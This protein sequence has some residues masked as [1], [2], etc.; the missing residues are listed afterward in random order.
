MYMYFYVNSIIFYFVFQYIFKPKHLDVKNSYYN[1][2][3]I[4]YCPPE[5]VPNHVDFVTNFDN[6]EVEDSIGTS[7]RN[8]VIN[9]QND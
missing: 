5:E 4:K 1:N 8:Y 9:F 2:P 3:F 6:D 7:L